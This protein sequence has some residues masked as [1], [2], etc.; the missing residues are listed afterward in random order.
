MVVKQQRLQ[1]L[2][3]SRNHLIEVC[4]GF[5]EETQF[6]NPSQSSKRGPKNIKENRNSLKV[7]IEDIEAEM[8]NLYHHQNT[9]NAN[10]QKILSEMKEVKYKL[11]GVVMHEGSAG[12]LNNSLG[13]SNPFAHRSWPLLCINL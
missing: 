1:N 6:I 8:T 2:Q 10:S 12:F 9:L 13:N 7:I 5:E 11:Q 4:H 3:N